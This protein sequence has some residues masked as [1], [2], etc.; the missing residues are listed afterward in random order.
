MSANPVGSEVYPAAEAL[1]LLGCGRAD[2]QAQSFSDSLQAAAHLGTHLASLAGEIFGHTQTRE[3]G[4]LARKCVREGV[5][6]GLSQVAVSTSPTPQALGYFL[7]GR[8]PT[9]PETAWTAGLGVHPNWRGQGIGSRLLAAGEQ[10]VAAAGMTKLVLPA[11]RER[12]GF[13]RGRGFARQRCI[14]TWMGFAHGPSD[15]PCVTSAPWEL[16]QAPVCELLA[17]SADVW[18]RMSASRRLRYTLGP[19]NNPVGFA[20]C[21]PE[22]RALLCHRLVAV[23]PVAASVVINL[24]LQAIPVGT[25]VLLYPVAQ[26]SSFTEVLDDSCFA[27]IQTA[28]ELIKTVLVTAAQ[29]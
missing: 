19:A 29:P 8:R 4:W 16:P 17:W 1:N 27:P 10:A 21:S 12:L 11:P 9:T 28:E 20:L 2:Q 5:D 26:V 22:G 23:Q 24:L 6:P 7:I 18:R 25:P 13:Y 3:P 15:S 14:R